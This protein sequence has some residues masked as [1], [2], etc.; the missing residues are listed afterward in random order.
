MGFQVV[1]RI[2]EELPRMDKA[3][4]SWVESWYSFQSAVSGGQMTS[5]IQ[6]LGALSLETRI[7]TIF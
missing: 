4:Y 3:L 1:A 2:L 7:P 5:I 6:F